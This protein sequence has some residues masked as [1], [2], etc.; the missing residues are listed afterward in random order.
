MRKIGYVLWSVEVLGALDDRV[1]V[2]EKGKGVSRHWTGD[3]QV[4]SG[5]CYARCSGSYI[6]KQGAATV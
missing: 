1:E 4:V 3:G 5:V 2:L 6:W